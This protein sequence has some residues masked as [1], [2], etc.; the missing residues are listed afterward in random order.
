M[1]ERNPLWKWVNVGKYR[2]KEGGWCTKEVRQGY[3]VG[4]WKVIRGG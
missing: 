2:L 3:G 4:V 1:C